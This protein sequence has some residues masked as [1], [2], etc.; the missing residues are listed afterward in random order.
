MASLE[1]LIATKIYPKPERL[2]GTERSG[3]G[4]RQYSATSSSSKVGQL[5]RNIISEPFGQPFYLS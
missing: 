1:G 2:K 3:Y 5:S 4:A